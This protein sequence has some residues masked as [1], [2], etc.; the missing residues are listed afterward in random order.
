MP[1]DEK[2]AFTKGNCVNVLTNKDHLGRR[3]LIVNSGK[4]WNPDEVSAD[5]LF[6]LFY[7]SKCIENREKSGEAKNRSHFQS[8]SLHNL[9]SHRKLMASLSLWT[10][11]DCR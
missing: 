9:K 4:L 8:T 7:L 11:M 10:L 1:D 5:Q 2:V 3:V 6:R